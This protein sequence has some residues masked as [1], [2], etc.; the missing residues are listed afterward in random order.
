MA[1]GRKTLDID[2]LTLRKVRPLVAS[3]NLAPNAN[4]ILS[5]NEAGEGVWVNTISN[6]NA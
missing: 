2:F 6:I 4:Y 3:T 5:V 1:A